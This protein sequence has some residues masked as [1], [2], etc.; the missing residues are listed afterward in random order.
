MKKIVAILLLSPAISYSQCLLD[1]S[2]F[3]IVLEETFDSRNNV[4]ELESDGLWQFEHYEGSDCSHANSPKEEK[5]IED[6]LAIIN[7]SEGN[8]FLEITVEELNNPVVGSCYSN[9]DRSGND[10]I[11][12]ESGTL[13]TKHGGW[14]NDN[15]PITPLE[16]YGLFEARI[17]VPSNSEGKA[18]FW[19]FG[20]G[21]GQTGI[22]IDI[23]EQVRDNNGVD[24]VDHMT[25]NLHN[26]PSGG[27]SSSSC[28]QHLVSDYNDLHERFHT[29][30]VVWTPNEVTFFINGRETRTINNLL[31]ATPGRVHLLLEINPK[32]KSGHY[33]NPGVR[34]YSMQVDWIRVYQFKNNNTNLSYKSTQNWMNTNVSSFSSSSFPQPR[35]SYGSIASNPNNPNEVYYIGTDD[36]LYVAKRIFGGDWTIDRCVDSNNNA[37]SN[38]KGDLEYHHLLNRLIFV[39]SDSKLQYLGK[40]GGNKFWKGWVDPQYWSRPQSAN[41]SSAEGCIDVSSN[42]NIAY[43]GH[44]D[45]MHVYKFQNGAFAYYKPAYTYGGGCQD[46]VHNDIYFGEGND[47]FY[48]TLDGRL[49]M[50]WFANGTYSHSHVDHCNS[51]SSQ[52]VSLNPGSISGSVAQ[53][54][55]YIGNSDSKLHEF[56]WSPGN[57][58]FQHFLVP[59]YYNDYL[60]GAIYSNDKVRSSVTLINNKVYYV[61]HDG[62]IQVLN[63]ISHYYWTHDWIDD[64]TMTSR[65]FGKNFWN[66]CSDLIATSDGNLVYSSLSNQLRTFR[67]EDCEVLN[68]PCQNTPMESVYL[69]NGDNKENSEIELKLSPNPVMD[70]LS[71]QTS[72][73]ADVFDVQIVSLTGRVMSQSKYTC[74]MNKLDLAY[75]PKGT[76]LLVIHTE[77]E[78]LIE[79][80]IK[81]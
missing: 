76:Y 25:N 17:K 33:P 39:G 46:L 34:D 3:E 7:G 79:R 70:K 74:K 61:G 68:P 15:K 47:V 42:G 40:L 54:I 52:K 37:F 57:Q 49:R 60:D 38:I 43:K 69:R 63:K 36:Q 21:G 5:Y 28:Q 65:Y 4:Q 56:R 26:W 13:Q 16:P 9:G 10:I 29:Y 19:L 77:K 78:R 8:K 64:Y 73:D 14:G 66:P 11:R 53:G 62:R 81:L 80:F 67:F 30:S 31:T 44:D 41:A 2:N 55:Y 71:F 6:R 27:N 50:F 58:S 20:W 24:Q 22:E 35:N 18:A 32:R 72:L 23:L 48:K 12:F 59:Y 75:L 51:S 1:R 45:Q